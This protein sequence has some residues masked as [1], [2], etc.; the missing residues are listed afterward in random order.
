MGI[1]RNCLGGLRRVTVRSGRALSLCHTAVDVMS[2]REKQKLHFQIL[3]IH[4]PC[5]WRIKTFNPIGVRDWEATVKFTSKSPLG[6]RFE[7]VQL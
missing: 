6:Y 4:H 5:F 7:V 1:G 3:T 2:L